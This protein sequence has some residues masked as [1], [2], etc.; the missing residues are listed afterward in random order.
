[1][2]RP[3]LCSLAGV[4]CDAAGALTSLC[5]PL[6]MRRMTWHALTRA[7]NHP[8]SLSSCG[9][10]GTLP[11]SLSAL[12]GLRLLCAPPELTRAMRA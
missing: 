5:V 6:V 9:L 1:M 4:G 7:P 3:P 11:D 10:R 12:H 2:L 8:R